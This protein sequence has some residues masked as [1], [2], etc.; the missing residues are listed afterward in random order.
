MLHL[1]LLYV[2]FN[3][4][5]SFFNSLSHASFSLYKQIIPLVVFKKNVFSA[6]DQMTTSFASPYDQ[7]TTSFASPYDQMTTSFA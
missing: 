3:S 2:I 7:M 5:C 6:Y 1:Y 4:L